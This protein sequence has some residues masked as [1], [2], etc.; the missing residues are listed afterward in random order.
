MFSFEVYV[1]INLTG[2]RA[3]IIV[4]VVVFSSVV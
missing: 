3:L 2:N 1:Q 4:T